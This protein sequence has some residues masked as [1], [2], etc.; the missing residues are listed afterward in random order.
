MASAKDIAAYVLKAGGPMSAMKL[1]KLVYYSQAWSLVLRGSPLFAEEI[2]AWAHG[3][4]VYE[5][6]E[7]HRGKYAV[8]DLG[9]PVSPLASEERRVV[10]LV[11]GHY[12]RMTAEQLS[13]STHAEK[14][15]LAARAGVPEGT[16]ASAF[17]STD[18]MRRFYSSVKAPFAH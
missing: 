14:P 10:D 13:A 3:P 8:R 4:V 11:V 1:Q 15:W 17:I 6:F 9:V 5:L 16:R 2:Q 12:G 18:T 7:L